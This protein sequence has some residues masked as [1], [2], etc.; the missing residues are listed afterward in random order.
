M[1]EILAWVGPLSLAVDQGLSG[2]S[3]SGPEGPSRVW[4]GGDCCWAVYVRNRYQM[5]MLPLSSHHPEVPRLSP[6][7]F[8]WCHTTT[9]GLLAREGQRE[10]WRLK[11]F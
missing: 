8:P 9:G 10:G 7:S 2:P 1:Q 5:P 3:Q 6:S 4:R 11:R